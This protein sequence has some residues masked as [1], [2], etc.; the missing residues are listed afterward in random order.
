MT[1]IIVKDKGIEEFVE[2]VAIAWE[3]EFPERA[4]AYR[5]E[6]ALRKAQLVH[7]NGVSK[8][9]MIAFVGCIPVEIFYVIESRVRGFFD[10]PHNLDIFMRRFMAHNSPEAARSFHFITKGLKKKEPK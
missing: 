8:E 4:K 7:E 9:G 6:M 1:E 10:D 3:S 5:D 2:N